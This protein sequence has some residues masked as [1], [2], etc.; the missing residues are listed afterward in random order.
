MSLEKGEDDGA[1]QHKSRQRFTA[2]IH[3]QPFPLLSRLVLPN[4]CLK[5]L[6]LSN[7]A[8]VQLRKA[9]VGTDC[10]GDGLAADPRRASSS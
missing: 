5:R 7:K 3:G 4:D 2:S 9:K 10:S 6:S 8:I 1:R